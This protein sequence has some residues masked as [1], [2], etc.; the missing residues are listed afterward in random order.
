MKQQSGLGPGELSTLSGIP[1]QKVLSLLTEME[2]KRW[3]VV[4]PGNRYQAMIEIS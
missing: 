1:I 4:E 2:L 3:I